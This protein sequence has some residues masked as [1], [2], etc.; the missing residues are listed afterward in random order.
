M[1][2][3]SEPSLP[4]ATPPRLK[5]SPDWLYLLRE[6]DALYRH[7][8]DGGSA[9]IRSHRKRVRDALS[10]TIAADPALTLRAPQAKPVTAHLPRA[11]DLGERAAMQGMARALRE[12][13]A[14][15]TW[16]YGYAQMPKALARKYAYCEVLGPHGPVPSDRL[17][18]GFVLFAPNTTYPQHSHTEI[19]ESYISIAGAWSENNAAVYAPGSLI[20]NRSGDE[21]RITTGDRDPC[22]L[23]YA[24]TGPAARLGA[25][26]MKLTAPRRARPGA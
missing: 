25:P 11:L 10:A 20:F 5:D 13:R 21:H 9:P 22:L 8:S 7:G 26:G 3:D 1:T 6:F 19:E 18:L 14:D 16:E 2:H 12:V 4:P 15:L 17:I 24:W 23:A